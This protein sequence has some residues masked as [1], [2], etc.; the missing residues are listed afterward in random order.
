MEAK[1]LPTG[2]AK[3]AGFTT[4]KN[5]HNP[6][7]N[8]IFGKGDPECRG[9]EA[10]KWLKQNDPNRKPKPI[11]TTLKYDIAP[12]EGPLMSTAVMTVNAGVAETTTPN[13][14]EV[15]KGVRM[16]EAPTI[17]HKA[18]IFRNSKKK[19]IRLAI[20]TQ[21]GKGRLEIRIDEDLRREL[22]RLNKMP[23]N[24]DKVAIYIDNMPRVLR[25]GPAG[26]HFHPSAKISIVTTNKIYPNDK[27]SYRSGVGGASR[28]GYVDALIS[29]STLEYEIKVAPN[30]EHHIYAEVPDRYWTK[31]G[32]PVRKRE[33]DN[34]AHDKKASIVKEPDLEQVIDEAIDAAIETVATGMIA[35]TKPEV[36]V[37][38]EPVVAVATETIPEVIVMTPQSVSVE[39]P[40][41]SVA[42]SVTEYMTQALAKLEEENKVS[43]S[44][45]ALSKSYDTKLSD[46]TEAIRLVNECMNDP[47]M[48]ENV[49]LIL[50]EN[51]LT[52]DAPVII[53]KRLV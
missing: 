31:A 4:S 28:Y 44:A 23:V 1:R 34:I 45:P 8:H 20:Y 12:T 24:S 39:P 11:K 13:Y 48:S 36:T 18:E 6:D 30:G 32:I 47:E 3:N 35:D 46:L 22:C 40:K 29:A 10:D 26:G 5:F 27:H 37:P 50:D 51:R 16:D 14:K 53:R 25:I 9:D 7:V 41:P 33:R 38:S 42:Q 2:Q 17:D 49:K 43:S 52:A 21:Q 19:N 15:S